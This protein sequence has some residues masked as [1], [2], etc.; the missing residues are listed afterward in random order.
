MR[1]TTIGDVSGGRIVIVD[2]GRLN[3]ECLAAQLRA[4]QV[5]AGE[6]W[7]LPSLFNQVDAGTPD[8]ILLNVATA[9]SAMLLQVSGD[10]DPNTKVVVY[11]LSMDRES[12][13]VAAAGAGV[14]GLHLRSESF[15][16]LLDM[17]RSAGNGQ[18]LCSPE[19]SA[20]LMKRVYAFAAQTNPDSSTGSL[21]AREN[22]ILELLDQ[23]LSNQQI[24]T[25]LSVTLHTVKNH[26]HSVLT[27][28][29]VSSRSEAVTVF[30]TAKYANR[31]LSQA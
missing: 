12:D 15:A 25:R 27:K 4:H 17:V 8:V 3:R 29:G 6:A 19:V 20:I 18:A 10:I 24:A 1:P 23:G 5:E 2:D 16:D 14:A 26:V 21:T 31:D 22:E 9:D 7:D 28:L 11:G 30:R 13:I